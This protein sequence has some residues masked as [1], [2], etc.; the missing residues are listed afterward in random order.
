V[1]PTRSTTRWGDPRFCE[2]LLRKAEKNSQQYE[3]LKTIERQGLLCKETVEN[4]L[5]FARTEKQ[6]LEHADAN[7]CIEAIVKILR[8]CSKKRNPAGVAADGEPSPGQGRRPPVAAGVSHLMTNAMA[9]MKNGGTL[10]IRSLLER[11]PRRVWVQFRDTGVGIPAEHMDRIFE[12]FFT[13]KPEGR[14]RDWDCS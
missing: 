3:D 14:A 2:L 10:T 13:T 5:S 12:P 1:S 4:L 11:N 6:A 8:H 9:A 7:Q